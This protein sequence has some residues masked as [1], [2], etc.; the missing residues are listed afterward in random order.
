MKEIIESES[1]GRILAT[2]MLVT[3]DLFLKF[4]ADKRHSHDKANGKL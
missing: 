3:D 4:H 1:V 2:T